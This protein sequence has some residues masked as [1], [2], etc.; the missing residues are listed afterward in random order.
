M[1]YLQVSI[2]AKL[3]GR[4]DQAVTRLYDKFIKLPVPLHPYGV[5]LWIS[6][7]NFVPLHH[8]C[9]HHFAEWTSLDATSNVVQELN[10][11]QKKCGKFRLEVF[12]ELD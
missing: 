7:L 6:A 8:R 12:F 1:T 9:A 3:I 11:K 10:M 2:K 5:M 4:S